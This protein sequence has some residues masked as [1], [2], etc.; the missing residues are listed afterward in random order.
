ME[1]LPIRMTQC[2]Q[3]LMIV[4]AKK[5]VIPPLLDQKA[6]C[7]G[8]KRAIDLVALE[9]ETSNLNDRLEAVEADPGLLEHILNSW[10]N[11]SSVLQ[12]I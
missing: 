7:S 10:R 1:A 4:L 6:P 8:K 5:T 9:N 2:L 3:R 12:F 11:G